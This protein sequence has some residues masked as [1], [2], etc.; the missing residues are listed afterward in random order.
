MAR[1]V[2]GRGAGHPSA[3]VW[4][5]P[6]LPTGNA[7]RARRAPAGGGGGGP[8]EVGEAE[9]DG[10]DRGAPGG[11][12]PAGRARRAGR[13]A[14]G[15]AAAM[16]VPATLM[17][18]LPAAAQA[19]PA[20][21][22]QAVGGSAVAA[23]DDLAQFG[24]RTGSDDLAAAEGVSGSTA[25]H[26][27]TGSL[28][29]PGSADLYGSANT[30]GTPVLGV[31]S[32]GPAAGATG[33]TLSDSPAGQR[34]EQFYVPPAA[35]PQQP[36]RI[37]RS[38]P[39]HLAWSVP[40]TGAPYPGEATRIMYSSQDTHGAPDAVTGTFF[41]SS[42][43]WTGPGERPLI[44]IAPGT[45]G[46]GDACAPSK[47]VNSLT[48][49]SAQSGP[50]VEYEM[51][52]AAIWL[53]KG[54]DVVLTDYEGLGTPAMH[55][56]VNRVSEAHAVIDAAR[57]AADL[58][59]TRVTD[60]TPI[61][62]YGYSQGGGAAAAAAELLP[63]Y[64]ADISGRVAGVVAG[65][66]PADLRAT[67]EQVDG[68]SLAGV[69][70]YALNSMLAAYPDEVRP[71]LDAEINDRGRSMLSAVSQQ[72]VGETAFQ[73]GFADTTQFTRTGE[74]L[75]Q[76]VGRYPQIADVMER[77]RI[78]TLAPAAPVL[79]LSGDHDDVVPHG[80]ARELADD[81]CALGADV[82]FDDFREPSIIDGAGL[83]HVIPMLGG[84]ATFVDWL[85]ARF[86]GEPAQSTC[87]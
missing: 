37:I 45:Q 47:L 27:V 15:L 41:R 60:A 64:G 28:G 50:M 42:A 43:P 74:S 29:A 85:D 1:R 80:Q 87:G 77:N 8:D 56:Y 23:L 33:S 3:A 68:T 17:P 73:F 12:A 24:R 9:V 67:L 7:E 76:I 65:A 62:V 63:T 51:I 44:V 18:L 40:G 32:T 81:W 49:G 25:A 20:G 11:G 79:V 19:A 78:G 26:G 69:I 31:G 66:P 13:A 54:A 10:I 39:S 52:P 46:Q 75:S 82:R 2:A 48:A 53:T 5:V 14:A 84:T 38:E 71:V 86:A 30:A 16:L 21:S 6:Y 61:G 36:G 57:A 34:I 59:G 83:G 72:C 4:G 22:A 35:L 55:T 70:G 58:P